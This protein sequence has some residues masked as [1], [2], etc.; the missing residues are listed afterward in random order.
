LEEINEKLQL[1]KAEA[2]TTDTAKTADLKKQI[3]SL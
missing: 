1:E 2:S 3:L